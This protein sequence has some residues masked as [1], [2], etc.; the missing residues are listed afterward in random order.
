M[1]P[2][3]ENEERDFYEHYH[4]VVDPGQEPLRID[5]FLQH[6][7]SGQSRSR[8]QAA[9]EAGCVLVNGRSVKQNYPVKPG[10][11]ISVVLHTPP[12]HIEAVPQNIPLDIVL[13]DEEF[14]IINKPAGMVV[15][16]AAGS[17][18]GTLVNALMWHFGQSLPKSKAKLT[19]NQTYDRVGLV[20]RID[21]NTSGLILI[22]KT[23]FSM[24][25]LSEYFMNKTIERKYQALCWGI[26]SPPEGTITGNIGRHPKDRKIMAVFTPDSNIGKPAVTHY[27]VMEDLG[28]I[29]LVECRLETGRTHQIR[30]HFSHIGHPLFSDEE[31]GGRIVRRGFNTSSYKAFV[32]NTFDICPRQA[33][34]SFSMKFPHPKTKKEIYVECPLPHDMQECIERWKKYMRLK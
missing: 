1:Q 17:Y 8:I 16:P 3:I 7:I 24:M 28:F 6:K 13:E 25:K 15:H 18:D 12:Q 21:K 22:A 27:K 4:F 30:A 10:D 31:Y 26:P 33:L 11:A 34:H 23:D 32:Q 14:I 29:S 20:H 2:G 9:C 19:E 5:K